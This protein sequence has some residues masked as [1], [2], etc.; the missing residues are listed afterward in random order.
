MLVVHTFEIEDLN[1]TIIPVWTRENV[2]DE[3]AAGA[4]RSRGQGDG[5]TSGKIETSQIFNMD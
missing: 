2:R 4:S 5:L 1:A 3:E